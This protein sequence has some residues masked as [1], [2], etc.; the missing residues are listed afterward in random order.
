MSECLSWKWERHLPPKLVRI[1]L[2]TLFADNLLCGGS[3][4]LSRFQFGGGHH[5][6]FHNTISIFCESE[7][8]MSPGGSEVCPWWLYNFARSWTILP[9]LSLWVIP[10][11][12]CTW[13]ARLCRLYQTRTAPNNA[14]WLSSC[15]RGIIF[16]GPLDICSN[17]LLYFCRGSFQISVP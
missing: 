15:V 13:T 1:L 7:P 17:S 5:L 3:G 14:H 10:V 9:N 6:S 11:E 12:T 2:W 16:L 8:P 4:R